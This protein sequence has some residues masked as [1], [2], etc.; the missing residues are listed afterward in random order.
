MFQCEIIE[1]PLRLVF[2]K[3]FNAAA[4]FNLHCQLYYQQTSHLPESLF[5][6]VAQSSTSAND[7]LI[8]HKLSLCHSIFNGQFIIQKTRGVKCQNCGQMIVPKITLGTK[9]ARIQS[10]RLIYT[11]PG[12]SSI[13]IRVS[14]HTALFILKSRVV[15]FR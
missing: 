5:A 4:C 1:L 11:A 6:G 15:E 2:E 10:F 14:K 3:P 13:I 8:C 7:S 9:K 12:T